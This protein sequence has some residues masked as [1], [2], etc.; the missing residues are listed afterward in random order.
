MELTVTVSVK[1][2]MQTGLE[3]RVTDLCMYVQDSKGVVK[4]VRE[5]GIRK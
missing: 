2:K 4:S 3:E 1:Y 5:I